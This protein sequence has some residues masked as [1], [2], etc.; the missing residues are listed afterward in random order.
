MTIDRNGLATHA[1]ADCIDRPMRRPRPTWLLPQPMPLRD[2]AL[3]ILTGPERVE[4]GWWDGGDVR[5]DYYVVRDQQRPARLGLLARRGDHRRRRSCCTAGSREPT[6]CLR[7][8]ALPVRLQFR[9][10]ASSAGELFERAKQQ[11]YR[12]L[13]ITDEA[14]LA[15][16]VRAL[17]AS[18]ATGVPL[19][20]GSEMHAC[21]DGP[22][23]GAAGRNA[24]GYH[25]P[26]PS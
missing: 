13:A 6:A 23:A 4:S 25:D 26:V 10:G 2:H 22:E 15:G 5:R 7:R 21:D 1:A 19:I 24:T 16:I 8:T 12:A 17:E 9:R 3:R 20:V 11:G 18:R 14:S